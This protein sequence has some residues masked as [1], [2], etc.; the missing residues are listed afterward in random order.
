MESSNTGPR[1]FHELPAVDAKIEDLLKN[2]LDRGGELLDAQQH[3]RGLLEAVVAVAEDLSLEAVLDRVVNSACRLLH[4]QYGA[5]GVIGEDKQLSHFITVGINKD[6]AQK[7]GPLPTGHGVLG[8]LITEPAP[9]RLHDLREHPHAYGFPANHPPMKTFLGVPI[10]VRDVVFGNLYLTDKEGGRDFTAEDEELAVALAAAAGVAIENARLY[11]DSRRRA[12]WLEACMDVTG[13]V[14]GEEHAAGSAG[15]TASEHITGAEHVAF[16]VVAE[17][18]L[19]ESGARLA[20]IVVPGDSVEVTSAAAYRVAGA[21]G[22]GSAGFSGQLLA[23]DSPLIRSVVDTGKTA[24]AEDASTVLGGLIGQHRG[25]LLAIDLSARGVHHGLL[26]LVRGRGEGPFLNSDVQMGAVFGSH[27]AVALELDRSHRLREELVVFTDR[28][29]IAR[30][31]HDV[32]IQ[33]LFAAGLSIQSLRRFTDGEPALSRIDAVTQEL[34]ETIRD[35]RNTIYSL[36]STS[37]GTELLSTR[38]LRTARNVSRPLPFAP[39]LELRGRIDSIS[40][41]TTGTHLLAVISE[42]LSNAVRHSGA[43]SIRVSVAVENGALLLKV[44]DDGVGFAECTP[45]N[46]LVNMDYRAAELG[47]WCTVSSTP[48]EGTHV[49]WSVPVSTGAVG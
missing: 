38:I 35:L 6:L 3:M 46:G 10:T 11:E 44:D 20:L 47:G 36:H 19:K 39:H 30:D 16:D 17:R 40:N 43:E 41:P 42:A 12:S 23:M 26:I 7:I 24:Q 5:L 8:Q 49:Q 34:D 29:R 28:D 9:L 13:R 48:G 25:R 27:V 32:V 15:V 14:L 18:A 37:N 2:F 31:L 22:K 1:R 45:G 4:A 33:R 21:A